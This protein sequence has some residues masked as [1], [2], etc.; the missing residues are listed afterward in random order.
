MHL[1]GQHYVVRLTAD[2]GYT[3]S[4]SY[5]VSSAPADELVELCVERLDDGEVSGYLYDAVEVGDRSR[6]AARSAAGSSG[7]DTARRWRSAA[8]PGWPRSPRCCASPRAGGHSD[9]LRV[10]VSARTADRLPFL[11]GVPRGRCHRRA[12]R[13]RPA[14]GSPPTPCV[15]SPMVRNSASSAG[16]PVRRGGERGADRDRT[17]PPTASGWNG[18][19]RPADRT[20]RGGAVRCTAGPTRT[21]DVRM[22]VSGTPGSN[23]GRGGRTGRRPARRD[24]A[25]GEGRAAD[26]VLLLQAA[27]VGGDRGDA[28]HRLLAAAGDGRGGASSGQVP[29]RCCSS[30][31]RP[32]STG[33]SG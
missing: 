20:R 33:C 8:E 14:R 3:A 29:A 18:S 6:S 7:P 1:A 2:D 9:Q 32:R 17:R 27:A 24:D 19:V 11:D 5:S 23:V 4:R 25:G 12:D 21:K 16:R 26:P 28:G 10:A 15:R 13:D 22:P 30:P 31:I